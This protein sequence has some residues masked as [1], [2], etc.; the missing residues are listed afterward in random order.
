MSWTKATTT[1]RVRV[2][3][4]IGICKLF[5]RQLSPLTPKNSVA[6]GASLVIFKSIRKNRDGISLAR[7]NHPCPEC[8]DRPVQRAF[9]HS[10]V[11][12]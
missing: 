3:R 4:D 5:Y 10:A 12:G 11:P 9:G 7:Y 1:A 8:V 6:C 2:S